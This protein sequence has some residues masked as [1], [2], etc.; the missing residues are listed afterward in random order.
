MKSSIISTTANSISSGGT[1]NGDIV[2]EGDLTVNGNGG[3]AYDEIV[4]GDLHVKSDSGNST[5]AFL[6]EKNDGT[7]VFIVDTQ[8]SK[9]TVG[10]NLVV[11]KAESSASEF[12]SAIEINRDFASATSTD[13]FTGMIFTDDNSVQAGIF[14]NRYASHLSLIHI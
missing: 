8:N 7:D 9:A 1:I 5:D 2:I 13:L 14:T 3:G 10:G 12:I 11:T 6:V 4:N